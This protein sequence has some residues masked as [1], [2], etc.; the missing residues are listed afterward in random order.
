MKVYTIEIDGL[1]D[2]SKLTGRVAFIFD[3]C[4]VSGWPLYPKF[5]DNKEAWEADDD[6]GKSGQFHGV[7][8]YVIFDKPVWQL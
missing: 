5:S 3:G 2:M 7:K 8:K 4:I 6:V 1:P